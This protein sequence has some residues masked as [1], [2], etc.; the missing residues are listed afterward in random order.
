MAIYLPVSGL[1][2]REE[3]RVNRVAAFHHRLPL[4]FS[5]SLFFSS[6]SYAR[7]APNEVSERF[8]YRSPPPPPPP[9][10]PPQPPFPV[11][12]SLFCLSKPHRLQREHTLYSSPVHSAGELCVLSCAICNSSFMCTLRTAD[13][14]KP[15]GGSNRLCF[16]LLPTISFLGH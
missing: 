10:P 13:T 6:Y 5:L 4:F 8:K 9:P 14:K 12:R 15:G 7:C 2:P 3:S 1:P 16:F 11:S